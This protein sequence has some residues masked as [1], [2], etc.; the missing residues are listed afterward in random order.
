MLGHQPAEPAA[1]GETRDAGRRDG[2]AGHGQAVRA[3]GGVQLGP[4]RPARGGEG[5]ALGVD[6]DV[7]HVG[8]ADHHPVVGDRA[9]GDVVPAAAHGHLESG[10]AGERE[11]GD[12]VGGRAAA[13]DHRRAAVD[14]AVV[15][16]PGLVVARIPG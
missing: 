4:R 10:A 11:R 12:H 7:V 1:E 13:D 16:G 3:G 2:A 15:D 5:G 14:E 9:S 6:G 8:E